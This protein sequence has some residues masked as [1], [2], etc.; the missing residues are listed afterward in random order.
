MSMD[1]EPQIDQLINLGLTRYEATAYLSLL[2][3]RGHSPAQ[4]A[5]HAGVPRQRI[6]DVL[7]ALSARGLCVER[8][9]GGQRHFYAVDPAVALPALL[10]ER[11]RQ[12]EAEQERMGG[13]AATLMEA[14]ASAFAA[15]S[16]LADPLDYVDVLLD[17]R[18]VA[19][20][21][22]QLAQAAEREICVLF[23]AP[24]V[25]GREENFAEVQAPRARGVRYR[26]LYERALL[27]DPEIA[28]WVAQF[29]RWGQEARA[30]DALPIKCNL[31]D[32]RAALLSLQD[33]V[34]GT[35][36]LTALCVTHPGLAQTLTI[37]FE[38]LW[39]RGEPLPVPGAPQPLS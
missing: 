6:Y 27:Q 37:A 33:P 8:H 13:Q 30:I 9:A 18:R 28:Q 2:G 26:A 7:A 12:F 15:G 36:S 3:R 20:R 32:G 11:R 17:R 22:V 34:T 35:P 19:E 29:R 5:A 31:Y 38:G 1:G 21:A 25:G 10:D 23:K 16:D 39:S 24:L 4:V 14:L